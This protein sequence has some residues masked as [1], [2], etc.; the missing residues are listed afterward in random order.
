M[1]SK[2]E[3]IFANVRVCNKSHA[4]TAT[5]STAKQTIKR[6][7][8]IRLFFFFSKHSPLTVSRFVLFE[9]QRNRSG[10]NW[11]LF[12]FTFYCASCD[13]VSRT[14][15]RLSFVAATSTRTICIFGGF[16]Y[17][18]A[19]CEPTW[20]HIHSAKQKEKELHFRLFFFHLISF[21]KS[22]DNKNRMDVNTIKWH[23]GREWA[24]KHT[25]K[26]KRN[27]TTHYHTLF[28]RKS[29]EKWTLKMNRRTEPKNRSGTDTQEERETTAQIHGSQSQ[30]H[31]QVIIK[32][33]DKRWTGNIFSSLGYLAFFLLFLR[34]FQYI[35]IF[36]S[37]FSAA[38]FPAFVWCGEPSKN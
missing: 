19:G 3:W 23:R 7:F 26:Q 8:F 1:C 21:A 28:R 38:I 14:R 4:H 17:Y 37:V 34:L 18:V 29:F 15:Y 30:H 11:L 2:E 31:T 24:S 5:H 10:H 22:K 33:D 27:Q 32:K 13:C 12:C 20:E 36:Y 25:N 16:V 6:T 35:S 9:L